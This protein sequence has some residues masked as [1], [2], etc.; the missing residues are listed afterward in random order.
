MIQLL[1]SEL[2]APQLA[3]VAKD[4]MIF[5]FECSERSS[6]GNPEDEA[7]SFEDFC[8]AAIEVPGIVQ[9]LSVDVLAPFEAEKTLMLE[10]LANMEAK[11]AELATVEAKQAQKK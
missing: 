3:Q 4:F 2:Q 10:T 6:V 9:V 1:R 8:A 5:A 7:L 11:Q